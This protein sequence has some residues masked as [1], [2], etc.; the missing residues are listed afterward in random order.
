M[1]HLVLPRQESTTR[2]A[3]RVEGSTSSPIPMMKQISTVESSLPFSCDVYDQVDWMKCMD[4]Y[5]L[6]KVFIEKVQ[7]KDQE[8]R[9]A[10]IDNYDR[11][12][13]ARVKQSN[14]M[15]KKSR[16]NEN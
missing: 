3:H 6:D 12:I 16:R 2:Q 5:K 10:M 4:C 1:R 15:R 13:K 7:G 8:S 14:E 9:Y 11:A